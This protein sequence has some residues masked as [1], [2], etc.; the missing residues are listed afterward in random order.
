MKV[1]YKNCQIEVYR[2]NRE[3]DQQDLIFYSAF[4]N[5][6]LEVISGYSDSLDTVRDWIEYIK[7]AIDDF[8]KKSNSTFTWRLSGADEYGYEYE[9]SNCRRHVSTTIYGAY[10]PDTCPYCNCTR[11]NAQ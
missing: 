7:V 6:G 3:D 4:T 5:D 1:N 10:L 2:G 8:N 9:C 11:S